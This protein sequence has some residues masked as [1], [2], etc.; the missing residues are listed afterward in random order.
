MSAWPSLK[1]IVITDFDRF[2]E[3][4]TLERAARLAA[5]ARPGTLALDLRDRGRS[6]RRLLELGERLGA[7][8]REFAQAL[9]VNDRL[10]LARLLAA[11]GCHLGEGSID[12]GRARPLIG[13]GLVVRACHDP[14]RLAVIEADIALLSPIL[15][16]RKGNAALGLEAL[17]TARQLAAARQPAPRVFALGGIDTEGAAAGVFAGADGVAVIGAAFAVADPLPLLDAL[18]IR[19]R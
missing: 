3:E 1:L 12:T 18:E 14:A 17:G 13:S 16:A 15:E 9:V 6:A 10:D 11:D 2:G 5:A 4:R 7:I 8:C 19:R